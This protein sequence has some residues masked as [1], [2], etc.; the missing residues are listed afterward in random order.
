M[1]YRKWFY[2]LV[3]S[4]GVLPYSGTS[5]EQHSR[6]LGIV[7]GTRSPMYRFF[8]AVLSETSLCGGTLVTSKAGTV[9]I[10]II[11][12]GMSKGR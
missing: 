12:I 9:I 4:L 3:L 1:E 7:G 11:L 8:V 5:S 6:Y 10:N 2:L